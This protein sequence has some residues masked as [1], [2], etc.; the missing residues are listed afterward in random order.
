MHPS[1]LSASLTDSSHDRQPSLRPRIAITL[2]D[3]AGVGPE[4]AAKLLADPQNREK[5]D[6]FVLADLAEVKAAAF[7]A[8]VTIPISDVAGPNGVKVLDDGSTPTTPIQVGEVSKEAGERALYQLKRAV[9]MA[10]K[11][12]VDAIVFTPL[13]KTSLHMAGM[14]E[15]DEL[16]WFAKYLKHYGVTSEINIIDGLWTAR[17]TSHVGIKDVAAI[18]TARAVTGAIELLNVLLYVPPSSL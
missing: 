18:I 4:L 1:T 8:G 6:I 17:V 15:E 13:N 11:G 12:E 16:R 2:G 7:V 3:H 10:N 9:A 14:Q 5:A